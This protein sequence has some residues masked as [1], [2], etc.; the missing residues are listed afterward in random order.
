MYGSRNGK[1]YGSERV[2][3]SCPVCNF[4][5][6]LEVIGPKIHCQ[7]CHVEQGHYILRWMPLTTTLNGKATPFKP[8]DGLTLQEAQE[9]EDGF[10]RSRAFWADLRV[11]GNWVPIDTTPTHRLA[12]EIFSERILGHLSDEDAHR[13]AQRY[14]G[15]V[16][17]IASV[18]RSEL[19]R[20]L[21]TLIASEKAL[22]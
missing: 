14:I 2:S 19:E 3:K 18:P 8:E 10:R 7:N 22:A 16:A 17:K 13:L 6:I 20:L 5:N 1:R 9:E 21:D 4:E 12:R 15:A 11:L